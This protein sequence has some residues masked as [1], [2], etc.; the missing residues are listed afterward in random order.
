MFG[1]SIARVLIIPLP[2]S[3][4]FIH[5]QTKYCMLI[6]AFYEVYSVIVSAW[7]SMIFLFPMWFIHYLCYLFSP[8]SLLYVLYTKITIYRYQL[9]SSACKD[10]HQ[11]CC[12][13]TMAIS[14]Y[15]FTIFVL[16]FVVYLYIIQLL[17]NHIFV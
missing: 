14:Y 6:S 13:L 10:Q 17:F 12:E 5:V 7:H 4:S 8:K 15:S 9:L 2:S 11:N 1:R 3:G 16:G